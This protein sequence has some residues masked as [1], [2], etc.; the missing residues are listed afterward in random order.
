M[1]LPYLE[2]T[3]MFV[4]LP[5]ILLFCSCIILKGNLTT[6]WIIHSTPGLIPNTSKK[7][8]KNKKYLKIILGIRRKNIITHFFRFNDIELNFVLKI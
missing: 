5:L 1:Y 4:T 2:S 6:P 7:K 8:K 3:D